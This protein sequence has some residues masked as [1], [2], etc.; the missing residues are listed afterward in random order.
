MKSQSDRVVR[1]FRTTSQIWNK[2]R[3]IADLERRS[4]NSQLELFIA[5]GIKEYEQKHGEVVPKEEE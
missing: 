2:L 5:E 4:A 1:Q 3:A